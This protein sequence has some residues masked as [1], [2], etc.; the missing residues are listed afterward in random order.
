MPLLGVGRIHE[1]GSAA[2]DF[3]LISVPML[4]ISVSAITFCLGSFAQVVVRD[5]AI[6]GARFAALA[7]QDAAAGCSRARQQVLSALG[8]VSA[9]FECRSLTDST[10]GLQ[11]IEVIMPIRMLGII[12]TSV[13]L[14][15]VGRAP[16]EL[17]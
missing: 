8:A 6:E 1:R 17:Q 13:Q 2:V 14:R 9:K 16:I 7:D 11:I 10:A 3:I 15:G 5:A 4:L 12:T